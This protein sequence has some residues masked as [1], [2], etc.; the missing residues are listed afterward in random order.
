MFARQERLLSVFCL[1][2][3]VETVIKVFELLQRECRV[4]IFVTLLNNLCDDLLAQFLAKRL[5]K[6][7]KLGDSNGAVAIHI[8]FFERVIGSSI[9]TARLCG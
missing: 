3:F 6:I 1:T 7:S 8:K 2:L 5:N 9:R 4:G